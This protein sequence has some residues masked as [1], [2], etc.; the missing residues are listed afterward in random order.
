MK[1]KAILAIGIIALFAG[2]TISPVTAADISTVNYDVVSTGRLSSIDSLQFTKDEAL[3]LDTVLTELSEKMETAESYSQIVDILDEF[4]RGYGRYPTIV[5][6]MRL[7]IK[8][9]T[10]NSNVYQLTP[11][12]HRAFVMSWGY[13]NKLNPLKDNDLKVFM[14]FTFWHYTGRSQ[15]LLNSRTI[16]VDPYPF[17]I[18]M[19]DGRQVGMMRNFV[20]VYI[21][22][23]TLLDKDMTLFFG[24]AAG[25]VGLDLSFSAFDGSW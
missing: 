4:I 23:R 22:R 17:N 1:M 8:V 12:R 14:P 13:S 2:M 15:Y 3:I 21:Y 6:L 20:G 19:M 16:I 25:V 24:H 9:V 10:F 18:K 5:A 11:F 7:F